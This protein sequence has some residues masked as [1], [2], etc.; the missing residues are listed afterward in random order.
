MV[1]SYISIEAMRLFSEIRFM[2]AEDLDGIIAKAAEG[3]HTAFSL[4]KNYRSYGKAK[5]Y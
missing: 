1:E 4:I 2:T 5:A 3:K